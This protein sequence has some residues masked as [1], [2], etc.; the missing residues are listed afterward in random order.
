MSVSEQATEPVAA[1][2]NR[3]VGIVVSAKMAKTIVVEVKRK[4]AHPLYRRVVTRKNKFYA[5]DE[6]GL[7]QV[8]DQVSIVECRPISKLKR[9]RLNEV[10]WQPQRAGT[11]EAAASDSAKS[12]GSAT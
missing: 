8:G 11:A 6:K 2:G 5:H 12:K 3:K 4:V 7:A 9:W 10:I 1:H